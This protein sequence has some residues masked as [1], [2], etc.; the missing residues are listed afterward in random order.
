MQTGTL[1]GAVTGAFGGVLFL[2]VGQMY[3]STQL[4]GNALRVSKTI[5]HGMAGGV[6]SVIQGGK[7]GHGFASAG[8]SKAMGGPIRRMNSDFA[9][10]VA[11]ALVGGTASAVTGGKFANGAVTS[12]FSYAF[13]S[14]VQKRSPA[15]SVG[16]VS[17]EEFAKRPHAPD[18]AQAANVADAKGIPMAAQEG[19]ASGCVL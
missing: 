4:S 12:A 19:G 9:Q 2:G 16:E 5:T 3:S 7:F 14:R 6:M 11:T 1:R 17:A 8:F 10:G 15:S 13:G 18:G